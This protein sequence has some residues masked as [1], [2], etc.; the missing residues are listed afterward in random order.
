VLAIVRRRLQRAQSKPERLRVFVTAWFLVLLALFVLTTRMHERYLAYALAIAPL[1]WPIGLTERR[2]V[3]MLAIT[4][5]A[6]IALAILRASAGAEAFST[7]PVHVVSLL[8]VLT[9]GFALF[10]FR[11]GERTMSAGDWDA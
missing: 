1:L 10:A 11:R 8:N 4:F 3:T 7:L 9:F 5:V 6:G 2:I